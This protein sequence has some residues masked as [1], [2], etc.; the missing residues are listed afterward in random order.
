VAPQVFQ[1]A[2]ELH[3]G[4]LPE[5]AIHLSHAD[6]AQLASEVIAG[7]IDAAIVT[8][9]IE[10]PELCVNELL[11]DR[12][13]ICLRADDPLAAKATLRATDFADRLAVMYDPERHPAAH[14]RLAELLAQA[15]IHVEEY[16]RASHPI[17]IQNFVFGGYGLALI[18]EGTE[19]RSGLITRPILGVTW[20]VDTAF[21]HHEEH[22][23]KTIP[24]LVRELKQRLA[25]QTRKQAKSVVVA[26]PKA[27]VQR[28]IK[29]NGKTPEQLSLLDDLSAERLSA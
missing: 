9:P 17:E 22:H 21:I 25:A 28:P 8:L 5:C 16:S 2:C 12:L 10:A 19:L 13:V 15:G 26:T 20:T 11:H 4:H 23:P 27:P 29:P 6:S 1:A 7:K 18:R 3:K 14:L 24:L